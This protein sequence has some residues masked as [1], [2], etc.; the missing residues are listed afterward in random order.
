MFGT[1]PIIYLSVIFPSAALIYNFSNH[2]E[3]SNFIY[4]ISYLIISVLIAFPLT[5]RLIKIF[6]PYNLKADLFGMDINKKGTPAGAIK[7]LIKFK[8]K[9]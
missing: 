6:M 3:N 2:K 7:M 1:E 9:Y 4:Y 8:K 5:L